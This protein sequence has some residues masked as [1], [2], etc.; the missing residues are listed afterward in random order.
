ML[1]LNHRFPSL[2]EHATRQDSLFPFL[3]TYWPAT[4]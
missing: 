1:P 2:V 3:S 4:F